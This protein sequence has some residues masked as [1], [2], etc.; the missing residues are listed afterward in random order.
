M[1]SPNE[2]IRNIPCLYVFQSYIYLYLAILTLITYPLHGPSS[3]SPM[4]S[5]VYYFTDNRQIYAH[6]HHLPNG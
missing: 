1:A 4:L 2:I 6:R 3:A 5:K